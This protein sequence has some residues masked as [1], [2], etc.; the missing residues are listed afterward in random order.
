MIIIFSTT[1]N[2]YGGIGEEALDA[3]N[4]TSTWPYTDHG[5]R[6]LVRL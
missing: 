5:S 2:C 3:E 1:T 4:Q 6:N